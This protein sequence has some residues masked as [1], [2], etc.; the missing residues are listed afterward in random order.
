MSREEDIQ[1]LLG[2]DRVWPPG[3]VSDNRRRFLRAL[4]HVL[5]R[6]P[7]STFNYV[8]DHVS[9]VVQ[10]PEFFALSVPFR[11]SVPPSREE[12]E[13]HMEQVTVFY[14]AFSLTDEALVGLVAHEIAHCMVSAD[15]YAED[16]QAADNL[17]GDWGFSA[18]LAMLR[19][20]R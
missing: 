17:V 9:F 3:V 10:D 1:Y 5:Q 4:I 12:R 6:L 18:E 15:D 19:E 2:Q 8:T 13:V 16:E 14:A 7:R 11:R 20:S